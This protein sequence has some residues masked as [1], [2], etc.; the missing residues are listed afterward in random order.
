MWDL[1]WPER[2]EARP[3][4]ECGHVGDMSRL[5]EMAQV[6]PLHTVLR[7]AGEKLNLCP[8]NTI[9]LL[10]CVSF[11][12]LQP[13]SNSDSRQHSCTP[14]EQPTA[15]RPPPNPPMPSQTSPHHPINTLLFGQIYFSSV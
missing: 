9:T 1:C 3:E 8:V 6:D 14:P 11:S 12:Y 15:Q 4:K 10:V 7:I 2:P 13:T 5:N